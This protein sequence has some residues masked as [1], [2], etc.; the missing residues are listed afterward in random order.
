MDA[1]SGGTGKYIT[2]NRTKAKAIEAL[3][4]MVKEKSGNKKLHTAIS[5]T[6]NPE[7]AEALKKKLASQF[8]VSEIHITPCSVVA[9]VVYG[10]RCVSLGF[11]AE[12]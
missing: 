8:E 3:L 5:Y 9:S 4:E 12:D 7:E 2:K 6:D 1:A 11:Y 10:P